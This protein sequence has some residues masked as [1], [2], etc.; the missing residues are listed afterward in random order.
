M[1]FV[2]KYYKEILFVLVNIILLYFIIHLSVKN[3]EMSELDRYKLDQINKNIDSLEQKQLDLN[4]KIK[5]YK[6]EISKIDS[7]LLQVENQKTIVKEYYKIRGEEIDKMKKR[8]IDSF[9]IN[10]YKY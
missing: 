3:S 8:D 7:T 1:E 4:Q 9:F 10:R 2:K 5:E 6:L